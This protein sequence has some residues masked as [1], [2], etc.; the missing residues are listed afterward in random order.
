MRQ[1]LILYL[2]VLLLAGL[3]VYQPALAWL[4]PV[5]VTGI[6]PAGALWLW[7]RQ[8]RT[9]RDLGFQTSPGMKVCIAKGFA[10]GFAVPQLAT[11]ILLAAG[12]I[13]AS[14]DRWPV[15]LVTGIVGGIFVGAL[16]SAL[17]V[18]VEEIVFRGFFIQ[19][20]DL[21]SGQSVA[22][23]SLLFGMIHMPAIARS[24]LSWSST[25]IGTLSFFLFGLALALGFVWTGRSLFFP[26]GLH[27]GYNLGYSL[28]TFVIAAIERQPVTLVYEGPVW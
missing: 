2:S 20:L 27:Y 12:I 9:F 14:V 3:A 28:L 25:L 22:V 18:L 6:L 23:A 1:G 19:S 15:A 13:S 10:I 7:H 21:T 24:G 16:R 26:L 4:L 5:A 17:T 11:G 8:G